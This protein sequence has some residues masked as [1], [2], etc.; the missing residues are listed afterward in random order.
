MSSLS[1]QKS[2]QL[3]S[4]IAKAIGLHIVIIMMVSFSGFIME[5]DVFKSLKKDIKVQHVESSVRVDVVALPKLTLQE[6]K[7]IELKANN[8][9]EQ[10]GPEPAPRS[11]PNE[12]SKVDFK[13][14]APK[15]DL[16]NLLKNL[17]QKKVVKTK[18][19]KNKGKKNF[20]A[21]VLKNLVIEGNKV[22]K[23]SSVTGEQLDLSQQVFIAY[24]QEL[25]DRIKPFWKLPT[26]MVDKNLQCRIQVFIGS[27]GRVLKMDLFESSGDS[28]YDDKAMDAVKKASPLPK[29]PSSIL[30]SVAGG[31]V[32]LGFPL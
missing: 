5:W 4:S 29:P 14:V 7:K 15:V 8:G 21:R 12:T 9:D 3:N 6:L 11:E 19:K 27:D 17:S 30:S 18:V 22:S 20:D 31:R 2:D 28:E 23:G 13:K 1:F 10:A 25:P 16:S 32:I 24:I 26:Y